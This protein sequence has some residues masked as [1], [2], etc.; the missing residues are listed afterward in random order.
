MGGHGF[1][2]CRSS[3]AG[4]GEG[5]WEGHS[6]STTTSLA[7]KLPPFPLKN[8]CAFYGKKGQ[9]FLILPSRS[10]PRWVLEFLH[11]L[12]LQ[13]W[14]THKSLPKGD[15]GTDQEEQNFNVSQKYS[16]FF[17]LLHRQEAQKKIM[18]L[19]SFLILQMQVVARTYRLF[20][21]AYAL[22]QLWPA[23]VGSDNSSLSF[24]YKFYFTRAMRFPQ[25]A[26]FRELL[27]FFKQLVA[28]PSSSNIVPCDTP[29]KGSQ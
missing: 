22:Q 26:H 25:A 5:L 16:G 2:P 24:M 3:W 14:V 1:W 13:I 29:W 21:I 10:S 6:H 18:I 7:P 15:Q 8:C 11:S 12:G 20:L 23:H 9:I 28:W 27:H 4:N 17:L 19:F